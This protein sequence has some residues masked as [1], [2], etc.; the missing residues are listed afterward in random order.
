LDPLHVRTQEAPQYHLPSV[1]PGTTAPI[2]Q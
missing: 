1:V 2:T